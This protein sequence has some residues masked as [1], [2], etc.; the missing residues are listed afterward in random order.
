MSMT[1]PTY[2]FDFDS[3][4]VSV[5][6]LDELASIALSRRG[7]DPNALT[8]LKEIT[9]LGMEGKIDFDE[10]L[11]QRLKL[12]EASK[13]DIRILSEML[14]LRISKSFIEHRDW[15]KKNCERIYVI[16]GGFIEYMHP[17]LNRLCIKRDHVFA[18]EFTYDERG[19]VN[20]FNRDKLTSRKGGKALQVSKLKLPKPRVIIGDGAT[21]LE[22]KEAG[23]A[24]KFCAFVETAD[25]NFQGRAD[26]VMPEFS[27]KLL[28]KV[29]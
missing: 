11:S 18:N 13:D 19:H 17:V 12:F 5:E 1:G 23:Y 20:G 2:I 3:T 25:R 9:T 7:N 22:I 21:D 15:F 8:R 10:S 28:E 16:S 26:L 6:S 14:L 24:E 4:L 27:P 29:F